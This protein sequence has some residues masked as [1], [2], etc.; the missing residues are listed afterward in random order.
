MSQAILSLV[1]KI[2]YNEIW[3]NDGSTSEDLLEYLPAV[4]TCPGPVLFDTCSD[5]FV[6][7]RCK[8]DVFDVQ[9][10]ISNI[11][12]NTWIAHRTHEELRQNALEVIAAPGIDESNVR[13]IE[14]PNVWPKP[15]SN[16]EIVN[17]T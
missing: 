12:F 6:R 11:F 4:R 17:L 10:N 16:G 13:L 15:G 5:S 3:V 14:L 9:D 8:N 7:S 1:T 2:C